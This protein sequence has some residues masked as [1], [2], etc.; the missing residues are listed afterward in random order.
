[1]A[2]GAMFS[3]S[4]ATEAK[5]EAFL[6]RFIESR[7]KEFIFMPI[8]PGE[9][10]VLH[11]IQKVHDVDYIF[12][13]TSRPQK[14]CFAMEMKAEERYTGNLVWETSSN[15][16]LRPGWG[17]TTKADYLAFVFLDKQR[18]YFVRVADM[19]EYIKQNC[20]KLRVECKQNYATNG[21]LQNLTEFMLVPIERL[22]E[23]LGFRDEAFRGYDGS[24]G[25]FIKL[26]WPRK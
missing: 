25:E 9:G 5:G 3:R 15:K 6:N 17:M 8:R 11:E 13:D 18:I 24:T 23:F 21:S 4:V 26:E 12:W 16:G 14:Q 2:S 10:S 22:G 7:V 19:R 1:M 20:E